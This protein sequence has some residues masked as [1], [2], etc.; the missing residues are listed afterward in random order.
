MSAAPPDP[1]NAPPPYPGGC[2]CG[3]VRFIFAAPAAGSRICHCRNCQR[4]MGAPF[5]AQAQFPKA[6]LTATGRT[7]RYRSSERL[8]RHFCP[9]CGTHLFLEPVDAPDRIGIP[10]AVLDDPGAIRPEQHVWASG[11]VGWLVIDDGLPQ[12]PRGSPDPYRMP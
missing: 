2:L 11:K 7:A 10:L 4:A 5:L 8:F 12:H 6:S 1:R 9:S 3:A